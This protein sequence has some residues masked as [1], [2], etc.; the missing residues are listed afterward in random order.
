VGDLTEKLIAESKPISPEL[1]AVLT[2]EARW[3][4]YE[5]SSTPPPPTPPV[6]EPVEVGELV[7]RLGWIAAQLGDI[8]WGDDSASVASAATLLSQLSAPAPAVVPVAV[9]ERLPNLSSQGSDFNDAGLLWWFKPR[10]GWR[11]GSRDALDCIPYPTHWLPAHAI[12]LPQAGEV[13]H[14]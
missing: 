4:L 14:V 7:Q 9:S 11:I 2:T 5:V 1:A 12:P 3:D 13:P 10:L 8:G 6:P